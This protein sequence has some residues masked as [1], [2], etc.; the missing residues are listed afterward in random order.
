[1]KP[2]G[3][4]PFGSDLSA[5]GNHK[6]KNKRPK[7]SLR[8]PAIAGRFHPNS[9]ISGHSLRHFYPSRAETQARS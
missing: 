5:V 7:I 2:G 3:L 6:I 8:D 4:F 1:M 9:L